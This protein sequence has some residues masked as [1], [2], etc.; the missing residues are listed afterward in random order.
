MA[1]TA[2]SDHDITL[3]S[4]TETKEELEHA[5]S[6]NWRQHFTPPAAAEGDGKEKT[7]EAAGE[8]KDG[9]TKTKPASEPGDKTK[10]AAKGES[11]SEDDAPLPKGAQKRIDRLTAQ[12][13][14]AQ[15][16]LQ[17]RTAARPGA[18]QQPPK[19]AGD[20]DPEPKVKDFKTWEEWNAAHGRWIVRDEQRTQ[21]AKDQREA[22]EQ[23]SKDNYDAHL[24]R[25]EDART[26]HDDFD[27]TVASAPAFTF[28]SEQSNIAFQLAVVEA[29]NGPEVLYHLA[30]NP[31]EMAKFEGLSP[32]K[33]Q[34]MVGRISHALSPSTSDTSAAK[35]PT[36]KTPAP[37]TPVKRSTT[38]ASATDMRDPKMSTDDWIRKRNEQERAQ[39]RRH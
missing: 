21:A 1:E 35:T 18:E 24:G 14:D 10:P 3:V 4:T 34:M 25:I 28:A 15:E 8:G 38:A 7:G 33:V 17:Q 5:T 19:A 22:A 12:L 9:A 6:E 11:G 39:R 36:S 30:K 27:D 29:D 37:T 20:A 2:L 26:A 32:V 13:R 16:Q 31:E 23:A